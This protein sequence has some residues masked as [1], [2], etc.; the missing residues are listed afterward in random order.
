MSKKKEKEDN[1]IDDFWILLL[2][3]LLFGFNDK[4]SKVINIYMGD[5]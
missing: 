1:F 5:E 3:P 4:P 2:L